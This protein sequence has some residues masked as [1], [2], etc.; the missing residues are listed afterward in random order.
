MSDIFTIT[1]I[2]PMGQWVLF[3]KCERGDLLSDGKRGIKLGNGK[4]L[5]LPTNYTTNT[6]FVELIDI[7]PK[8]QHFRREHCR[9]ERRGEP[10]LAIW[11]PELTESLQCVDYEKYE[12]WMVKEDRLPHFVVTP[13]N[14]IRPLGEN[15]L[16]EMEIASGGK[17]VELVDEAKVVTNMGILVAHGE[18]AV[19]DAQ[20]G[21]NVVIHGPHMTFA[22]NG[23]Q[24]CVVSRRDIVGVKK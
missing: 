22:M 7:G 19:I 16:I 3:R 20:V 11:C 21:D 12:Y 23:K 6:N 2:K 10:G 17:G 13:E 5:E 1:R 8:C 24:Y 4:E 18:K 9:S 14:Y 15:A